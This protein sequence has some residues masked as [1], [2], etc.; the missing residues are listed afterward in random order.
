MK[1]KGKETIIYFIGTIILS[2]LNFIISILYG[3][4]FSTND[5]GMY[6]LTFSTYT[7]ISQL[8]IG[9]VSQSII[10]FYNKNDNNKLVNSIYTFHIIASSILILL[11][12]LIIVFSNINILE[13]F[14]Y[15]IFS[16]AFF[17]ESYLLITNTILRSKSDSKQYSKNVVFNGFLKIITLLILYYVFGIKIVSVIALSLLI[18]EII[19]SVHLTIKYKLYNY[20]T[21]KR[22]DYKLL[23]EMFKY[24]YP[25]IG[26]SITSWILNVSD[27]YIIK[28]FYTNSEVGVYSYSYTIAN[29]IIMLV[30]QFIMLGAYP[31][32][33]STWE[34]KGKK[35]TIELIKKYLNIY[36]L[37][38]IPMCFGFITLGKDFFNLII[39]KSY[40]DGYL[41]FIITSIGIALLGFSQYTNKIWELLKKTKTILILNLFAALLNII[42]NL[43]FIP[44]YGSYFGAV[45]TAISFVIYIIIS[46]ILGKKHMKLEID[47]E[48]LFKILIASFIMVIVI[49]IAKYLLI[50]D[51]IAKFLL[52]VI[53]SIII[54]F[55]AVFGLKIIDFNE[56]KNMIKK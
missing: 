39:N 43:I 30:I 32:I 25:L 31:N 4:M 48:K 50:I 54:Y 9:W 38:I 11:F 3:N 41:I 49:M 21:L 19:Q 29:S 15:S 47:I 34:N 28:L 13:K 42:L 23:K 26:V 53:S 24:G 18:S 14:L 46:L 12:N 22:I 20:I 5:F 37:I 40:Y 2:V 33:V 7:L 16:I 56:V 6:S 8:L 52:A 36:L 27:R 51:S 45:T 10:R 35:D 17:F 44:I 1:N 55:I